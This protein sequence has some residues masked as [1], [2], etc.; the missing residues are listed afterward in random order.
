M[1]CTECCTESEDQNACVGTEPLQACVGTEPLQ[2]RQ[3]LVFNAPLF[4]L[5]TCLFKAVLG[6]NLAIRS[7]WSEPQSASSLV[8]ADY[9][10]LFYLWLQR[11]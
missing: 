2:A 9:I 5:F 8:F 6:L 7:S 3:G 10:E 4:F 11:I 1:S